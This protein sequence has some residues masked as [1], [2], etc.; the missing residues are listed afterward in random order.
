M[1][2]TF[3]HLLAEAVLDDQLRAADEFRRTGDAVNSRRRLRRRAA[4]P[5]RTEMRASFPL[6]T[7]CADASLSAKGG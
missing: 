2:S 5:E 7:D 1:V 3:S 4:G 6:A